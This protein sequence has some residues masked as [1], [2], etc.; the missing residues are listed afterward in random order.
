M[1][2]S[3]MNKYSIASGELGKIINLLSNDFNLI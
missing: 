1:K 3:K 2:L